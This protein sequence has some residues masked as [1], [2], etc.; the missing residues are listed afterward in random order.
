VRLISLPGV[1]SPKSDSWLLASAIGGELP[2]GASV[3]DLCTGSGVL[4]VAAARA[5]ARRVVA[6]D[7]SRR[8]AL[9]AWTNARL[10]GVRIVSR[11]GDLFDPVGGER[12]DAIVSN[13]P[14][15]PDPQPPSR[16]HRASRGWRGGANGRHLLD[17]ICSQAPRHLAAGGVL[18]LVHSS[19]NDPDET[20]RALREH[21]LSATV[22]ARRTGPLGPLLAERAPWLRRAGML[23]AGSHQ[24][25]LVV[26]RAQRPAARSRTPERQTA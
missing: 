3:L 5:G 20:I 15:V 11:V 14:Y 18:L 24:E 6:V 1:F 12:F 19:V 10:N 23:A 17:R 7:V 2:A 9:A 21:G 25:D 16:G 26:V 13:P 22:L 8:A 4:A